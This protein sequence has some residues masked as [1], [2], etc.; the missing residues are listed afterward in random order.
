MLGPKLSVP[1]RAQLI[2]VSRFYIP[3]I[4]SRILNAS[5]DEKKATPIDLQSIAINDGVYSDL[6]VLAIDHSTS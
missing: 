5:A 2:G 1:C 3:Y 4:A 6:Y